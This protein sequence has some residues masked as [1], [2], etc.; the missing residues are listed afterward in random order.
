METAVRYREVV[1]SV[2]KT[3]MLESKTATVGSLSFV[4]HGA[5][6]YLRAG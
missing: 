2:D 1:L 6:S 4:L 5:C 3:L